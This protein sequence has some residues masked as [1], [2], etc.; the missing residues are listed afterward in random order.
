VPQPTYISDKAPKY[1]YPFG[2]LKQ[3]FQSVAVTNRDS[4]ISAIPEIFGDSP[5]DE[6]IAAYQ[7]WI[8]RLRWV[9][10]NK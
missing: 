3:K 4:R 10:K 6:L 8:K 9:I 7:N 1:F 2:N 5:Q